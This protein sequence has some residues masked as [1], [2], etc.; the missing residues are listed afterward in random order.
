M[1]HPVPVDDL[2]TN[3][4]PESDLPDS[5]SSTAGGAALGNPNLLRQGVKG[6]R[7]SFDD[8]LTTIGGAGVVGGAMG[9]AAPEILTGLG[10]A[11]GAFPA[12]A[13]AAPALTGMANIIRGGR[14]ASAFLGATGGI[15]GESAGQ[16]VEQTGG[17]QTAAEGARIL[18]GAVGPEALTLTKAL[19]K[20]YVL[21]PALGL[22]AHIKKQSA[23]TLL[24]KMDGKPETMTEQEWKYAQELIS[25]IRGP[26]GKTE[27]PLEDVGSIMGDQG[28]RLLDLSD[29]QQ[30]AAL[31]QAGRVGRAAPV[32]RQP[33]DIGGELQETILKNNAT[34]I[35]ARDQQFKQNQKLRDSIVTSKESARKYIN[36][37][38]EY[39]ALVAEVNTKL[40]NSVKMNESLGVQASYRKILDDLTNPEKDVFGQSKPLG[41]TAVDQVRRKLG[42]AAGFEGKPET[43][44]DAIPTGIAKDLYFKLRGMQVSY[45]GGKGGPQEKLLTD[46]RAQ[47]E[48]LVPFL[49]KTGKKATAL[50]QH[51]EGEFA[52]DPST[53]PSFYFKTRKSI[54]DLK[55]LTGSIAQVNRAA[56]NYAD[57]ELSG[58]NATQSRKWM[59]DNAEWLG[60]AGAANRVVARYVDRLEASEVATSRAAAFAKQAVDDNKLL[61]RQHLPAQRAVDLINSRDTE[62]WAKV[63]PAIVQSPQ[64]KTQMVNAVRQVVADQASSTNTINLFA[65]NIR[66]FLEQ[67]QIATKQEMDFISDRLSK[68]AEMN[69]PE[70]EKLGMAKRILLQ[71]TGT[72]AATAASR[73]GVGSYNYLSNQVPTE[74]PYLNREEGQ[75]VPGMQ[76]TRG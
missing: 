41:F 4:V 44:Y 54:N 14:G 3:V 18:G 55:E 21:K 75:R 27:Q 73:A 40:D 76:G 11:A 47:S 72:W 65:R 37:T 66:P 12:T 28:R 51:I 46:Y 31:S 1:G 24:A 35:S 20:S 5:F 56:L 62:L 69:I 74:Q 52:A 45:A 61:T 29:Q 39:E 42:A 63:V 25:E 71:S 68:I 60:E 23:K 50:D 6:A 43:G 22:A 32:T 70:P 58:K 30:I 33:A 8:T 17:S 57:N 59:T 15:V 38:P 36:Q 9:Y 10:A 64:A 16:V 2:P 67:S 53:L 7:S 34:A 13:G 48:G 19:L 26:G 49:T